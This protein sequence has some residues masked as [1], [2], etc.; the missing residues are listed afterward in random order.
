MNIPTPNVDRMVK[1]FLDLV[2]IDSPSKQE[3]GVA[4][5]L[6]RILAPLG[7]RVWQDDAGKKIGGNCGNLH[8]RMGAR[9]SMAPALLFSAHMDCVMPCM[10]VKP[11]LEDGVIRTDGTTVL[12]SDDKA[13]VAAIVEM[14]RCVHESGMP[15]G[16]IEVIFDVAEEIGLL[17][18][19]H[20]DLSQVQAVCAFVLD[21]EELDRV[22]YRAPSANRMLYELE[23]FASHAG[24][25]PEKGVSTIEIFAEAVSKMKLGRLDPDSTANIG[26]VNSG[27]ATNIVADKLT[28]TAEARSH[29][30]KV[31]DA[32]TKHMSECFE[33]AVKKF[34]K[35][36]DGQTLTPVFKADIKREFNAMNIPLDS[37]AYKLAAE[38]GKEL[39]WEMESMSIGGGTNANVYNEKGLPAVVI[40][41]GMKGEHTTSEHVYVKD[42]ESSVKLCLTIL[43][44]NHESTR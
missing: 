13:G 39:G 36:V 1:T 25:A 40:G 14:L 7:V 29:N 26:T 43:R 41:C 10:G 30:N 35:V 8:V 28:A 22:V 19:N 32:Q 31:L 44:K 27:R 37:P 23:G 15:H 18:A 12:G 4:A 9:D 6:E 11:R 34:S 33:A 21:G 42:I 3:S 20:V 16:P 17:G 38:S 2:Q 5:Y 24:M